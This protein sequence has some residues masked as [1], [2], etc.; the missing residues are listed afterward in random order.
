MLIGRFLFLLPCSRSPEALRRKRDSGHQ[1]DFSHRWPAVCRPADRHHFDH[2]RADVFPGAFA[3]PDRRTLPDAGRQIILMSTSTYYLRTDAAPN[4]SLERQDITSL[5]PKKLAKSRPLFDPE[6][7]SRAMEDSFVKLNPGDAGEKSG[8]PGGRSG[9]GD[10]H[11]HL[12]TRHDPQA[13]RASGFTLQIASVAVVHRAVRELRGSHGGSARQSAGRYAAQN[14]DRQHRA[15]RFCRTGKS[16]TV[17]RRSCAPATSCICE[18]GDTIPGDGDVIDGIA[19]VDES[20]IT[21]KRARDSRIGR[22]PQRRDG[23]HEGAFRSD[24]DSDHVQP[25]RDVSRPHDRAGGRR[26][27]GRRRRTK[28]RSIF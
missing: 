27:S 4:A 16:E 9:R 15:R 2:R 28:S 17:P 22:R 26:A 19:T 13:P 20:V 23:R 1:R 10:D 7:L 14:Q 21:G 5:L 11:G 25:R 8:D 3:G 24:Q 12:V 6:I 18:A